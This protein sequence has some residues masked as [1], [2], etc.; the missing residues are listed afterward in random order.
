MLL[1]FI[2]ALRSSP[3]LLVGKRE[4]NKGVLGWCGGLI[5]CCLEVLVAVGFDVVVQ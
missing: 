1:W 5:R 3:E 4:R 2:G